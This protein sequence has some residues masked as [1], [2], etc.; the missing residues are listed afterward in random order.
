[1]YAVVNTTGFE[2]F[3]HSILITK[4]PCSARMKITSEI[5]DNVIPFNYGIV[6]YD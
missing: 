5:D 4:K 2:N 6:Y 1:M 3:A